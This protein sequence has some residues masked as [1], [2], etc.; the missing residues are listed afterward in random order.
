MGEAA[1]EEQHCDL[2][3]TFMEN[4]IES[5]LTDLPGVF[6]SLPVTRLDHTC[7]LTFFIVSPF[8]SDR[9]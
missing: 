7:C 1:A 9:K 6:S 3:N 5:S 8:N 2:L 4:E